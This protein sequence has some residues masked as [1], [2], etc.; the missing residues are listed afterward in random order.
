MATTLLPVRAM[1]GAW[2]GLWLAVQA[3]AG[4]W[5]VFGPDDRVAVTSGRWPA[6]AIGRVRGKTDCTGTLVG[7]R[8][9]LTA[10]HCL[11]LTNG[12]LSP[13][14]ATTF[15]PEP[16]GGLSGASSLSTVVDAELGG[17]RDD[18]DPRANDWAVLVLEKA[19]R[20]TSGGSF[21]WVGVRP[22]ALTL[23]GYVSLAGYSRDFRGGGTASLHVGCRVQD[24]FSD[25]LFYHDC[26]AYAG[27]SGGPILREFSDVMESPVPYI[28]GITNAHF[29]DG[30]AGLHV[31][32]YSSSRANLGT[33]A[34]EMFE[35]VTR[36]QAAYPPSVP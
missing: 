20:R 22:A 6:T 15:E 34:P 21:G 31:P 10:A 25:G 24:L 8:L 18:G 28:V 17:W 23:G 11:R 3:N 19:P 2:M 13:N 27:V 4:A 7:E 33:A 36:L 16:R 35:A 5:N 29:S 30:T 26:D 32:A 9:V 1:L 12:A 14:H